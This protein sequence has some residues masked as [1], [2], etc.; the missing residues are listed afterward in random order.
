MNG[1]VFSLCLCSY[2]PRFA[3]A[4]A[5]AEQLCFAEPWSRRAVEEFFSYPH[6][7]AVVALADGAFAGYAGYTHIAD[8]FEIA[9]VA[10]LPAFRRCGVAQEMLAR[11]ILTA[12]DLK[13]KRL[14]LEVR[15]SGEAAKA[16]YAKVGFVAVGRRRAFY[17]HPTEDALLMDFVLE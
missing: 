2:E 1:N 3:D 13:A 14:T 12:R 11:L 4:V 10:V 5:E 8:E 6:N 16:L 15:E 17:K 7:G 9:N